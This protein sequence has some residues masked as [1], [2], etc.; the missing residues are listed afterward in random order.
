MENQD[1]LKEIQD[2]NLN[3]SGGSSSTTLKPARFL[4]RK[5]GK[6]WDGYTG[7][8]DYSHKCPFCGNES[9]FWDRSIFYDNNVDEKDFNPR[10]FY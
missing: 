2:E 6:N 4:C 7:S 3:I 8:F 9:G 1:N 10:K 5:C